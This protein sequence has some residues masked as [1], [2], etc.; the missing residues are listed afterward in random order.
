[1]ARRCVSAH[2]GKRVPPP[3]PRG[4]GFKHR[5]SRCHS[6]CPLSRLLSQLS[7][8]PRTLLSSSLPPRGTCLRP[9]GTWE[10]RMLGAWTLEAKA[11]GTLG[12]YA[13]SAGSK[14][15]RL[16][17]PG[18]AAGPIVPGSVGP[19]TW[20][21]WT[22]TVLRASHGAAAVSATRARPPSTFR[23]P[24]DERGVG[25]GPASAAGTSGRSW[26]RGRRLKGWR[27]A[28]AAAR[29]CADAVNAT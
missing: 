29:H 15:E 16:L 26:R 23:Q 5:I 11:C 24:A 25:W 14:S 19:E 3:P 17:V 22:L 6:P 27:G 12:A 28:A 7:P 18:G 10:V 20:V 8:P 9:A 4:V 2:P 13:G 1:M 21:K